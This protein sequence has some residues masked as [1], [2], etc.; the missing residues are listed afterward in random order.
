MV[1]PKAEASIES[2]PYRKICSMPFCKKK[3]R[4]NRVV[5]HCVGVWNTTEAAESREARARIVVRQLGPDDQKAVERT[6]GGPSDARGGWRWL[7]SVAQ[8]VAA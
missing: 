2:T 8:H 1:V 3:R 7:R 5:V 4:P 6:R